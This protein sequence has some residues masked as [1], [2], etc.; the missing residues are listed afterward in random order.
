MAKATNH[1]NHE[2]I[3]SDDVQGAHVY[4]LGRTKIGEVDHLMIDKHTGRIAYAV[5]S[6]G[7]FFGMGHSHYPAPWS[8]LT[9]DTSLGGFMTTITESQ[10]KDA[11]EFSDDSY[12]DRSAESRVHRH[13]KAPPYW[14][15]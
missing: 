6:F 3:S 10:L 4:G 7:G 14:G 15:L 5:I 11:P 1:P 12:G 8:T 13:F 9:Y 2:L